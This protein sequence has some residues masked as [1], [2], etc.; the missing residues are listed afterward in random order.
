MNNKTYINGQDKK[1]L[2]KL[3]QK[4]FKTIR[5]LFDIDLELY[6]VYRSPLYYGLI[7]RAEVL[8]DLY[9]KLKWNKTN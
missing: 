6:G 7:K 3:I 1:I 2:R 5:T 9:N 8:N 4:E